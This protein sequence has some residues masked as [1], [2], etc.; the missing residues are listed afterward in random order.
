MAIAHG[1]FI[2]GILSGLIGGIAKGAIGGYTAEG[3][4]KR[5]EEEFG[6]NLVARMHMQ[7]LEDWEN[8]SPEDQEGHVVGLEQLFPKIPIRAAIGIAQAVEP[9]LGS[10]APD[11][12][13]GIA[14][15]AGMS[16]E[17][18]QRTPAQAKILQGEL[19]K[20]NV[21]ESERKRKM[22]AISAIPTLT[23]DEQK[24][25]QAEI[26]TGVKFPVAAIGS[27]SQ[28]AGYIDAQ[29]KPHRVIQN[30][31]TRALIDTT[32]GE[33]LP[34]L[35]IDWIP[36][37]RPRDLA[38]GMSISPSNELQYTDVN[39]IA[40]DFKRGGP[41]APKTVQPGAK[42]RAGVPTYQPLVSRQTG[43]IEG[44]FSNRTGAINPLSPQQAATAKG[45]G[46]SQMSTPELDARGTIGSL[47]YFTNTIDRLSQ[48]HIK[49]LGGPFGAKGKWQ[50][51]K[52]T[53][54]YA[55]PE[56]DELLR[57]AKDAGNRIVYLQSGKQINE[58]EYARL[59]AAMP[60]PTLPLIGFQNNLK[61]FKQV[62][63]IMKKVRGMGKQYAD[64][65]DFA[66]YDSGR[67]GMTTPPTTGNTKLKSGNEIISITLS[68]NQ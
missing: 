66:G 53:A 55:S 6:K 21:A 67:T 61:R 54:G 24:R 42:V 4:R 9:H 30:N 56:M 7:R 34:V 17:S 20:R 19:Y 48:K 13:A 58:A 25:A 64:D 63:A 49:E 8:L 2:V 38:P 14:S 51:L 35:P 16:T 39:R 37:A 32:T 22:T 27:W 15:E 60:N 11:P 44:T 65:A 29:N 41:N 43:D 33:E 68:P 45:L 52:S 18:R 31:K 36:E 10:L 57:T 59:E 5:K 23:P 50:S 40:Q 26:E 47:E 28:P 62:L 12:L 1:R 3:E 46:K